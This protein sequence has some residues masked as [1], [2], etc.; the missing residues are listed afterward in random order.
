MYTVQ[1]SLVRV[2]QTWRQIWM[3]SR[4]LKANTASSRRP[5][6][7]QG[8]FYAEHI[9]IVSL[10]FTHW[11]RVFQTHDVLIRNSFL[12]TYSLKVYLWVF[13]TFS[14]Q[15]GT[16]LLWT[17]T[18]FL[19]P[20]HSIPSAWWSLLI[21]HI[22]MFHNLGITASMSLITICALLKPKGS[23]TLTVWKH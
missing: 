9:F 3:Q 18:I 1:K 6:Q 4:F 12:V 14:S 2:S 19:A 16:A 10:S 11:N 20:N 5:N 7:W 13:G 8:C 23:Q 21:N 22:T 15:F 17:G